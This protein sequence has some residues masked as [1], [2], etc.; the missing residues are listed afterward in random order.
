MLVTE[1]TQGSRRSRVL[2]ADDQ[3]SI[4]SLFHRL[5]SADGHDVVWLRMARPHWPPSTATDRTSSFSTWRCRS[6]MACR[7]AAS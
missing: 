6:L 4:R 7:S 5:L 3:E 1:S 2:I